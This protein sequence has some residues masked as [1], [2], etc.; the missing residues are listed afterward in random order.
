MCTCSSFVVCFTGFDPWDV[1]A[2]G[3][4]DLLETEHQPT[5]SLAGGG[6]GSG[7]VGGA[8]GTIPA[9]TVTLD[10]TTNLSWQD[11]LKT[12]FPNVNI[13]FGGDYAHSNLLYESGWNAPSLITSY[14][15]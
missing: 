12:V 5:A 2:R 10:A 4:A 8:T 6:G 15:Q 9:P 13:S 1:S 11:E 14:T 3:L 7:T